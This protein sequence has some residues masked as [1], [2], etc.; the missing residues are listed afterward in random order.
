MTDTPIVESNIIYLPLFREELL[1][2]NLE[3]SDINEKFLKMDWVTDELRHEVHS[4]F[5]E[6]CDIDTLSGCRK[7]DS[8]G[9]KCSMLFPVGRVFACARQLTQVAKI[10]LD[11]WAING[12]SQGRKIVC[13]YH[14]PIKRNKESST[15][16]L[17]IVEESP[18]IQYKCP[19]EIRFAIQKNLKSEKKPASFHHVK[20]TFLCVK[21]TC[22]LDSHFHR[23]ALQRGGRLK[24]DLSG[25]QGL[26]ELLK[27]RPRIAANNLRPLLEKFLPHYKGVSAQFVCNFRNRVM[28]YFARKGLNNELTV[29]EALALT[30]K[31]QSA[32]DEVVDTDDPLI[33]KNINY[34]LRKVMK[35]DSGTWKAIDYLRELKKV[36]RDLNFRVAYDSDGAPEGILWMTKMMRTNVIKYGDII[37]LDMQKR[38]Y[39]R[40]GF[41]FCSPVCK[42]GENNV[43]PAAE[44][45]VIEESDSMYIWIF[46]A[47]QEIEPRWDIRNLRYIF[48]DQG[49]GKK[50]LSQLKIDQSCTLRGDYYHLYTLV[51]PKAFGQNNFMRIKNFLKGMLES[52]TMKEWEGSYGSAR[53]HLLHLPHLAE[54]LDSIHELPSYYAGYFLEQSGGSIGM[55]GS[56]SAEQNHSSVS[57]HLGDGAT[58][59]IVEQI[60][61][62]IKRHQHCVRKSMMENN[63][64]Y[65]KI[66]KYISPF[67]D[68]EGIADI[69]ARKFLSN[70]A[71]QNFWLVSLKSSRRLQFKVNDD[72]F[73]IVWP[74]KIIDS[75]EHNSVSFSND[76]RCPCRRRKVYSI[77]C[78]HEFVTSKTFEEGKFSQR[79]MNAWAFSNTLR[80]LDNNA[81]DDDLIDEEIC[82][83]GVEENVDATLAVHDK[84]ILQPTM[85]EAENEVTYQSLISKCTELV[86]VIQNDK[87]KMEMTYTMIDV[88]IKRLRNGEEVAL[89][90]DDLLP[91]KRN[92]GEVFNMK[93]GHVKPVA[94]ATH[95]KRK[96]SCLEKKKNK[97]GYSASQFSQGDEN[98]DMTLAPPKC[99][100]R[101]C[102]FCR[103]PGHG[104]YRCPRLVC[105]G[106]ILEKGDSTRRQ[107]L[108]QQLV[109]DNYFVFL[110]R[111]IDDNK[112][113]RES[114]PKKGVKAMVL[115]KKYVKSGAVS[116]GA[117]ICIEAT[118]FQEEGQI[119]EDY[120]KVLFNLDV[121]T[122]FIL[123]SSTNLIVSQI[124]LI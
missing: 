54:K 112:I 120:N 110:E 6:K 72:G 99:A 97:G 116:T 47:M 89:T 69:A 95:M 105:F 33:S 13:H 38:Q 103:L 31:S 56:S 46:K 17:R 86:G 11:G 92:D 115:H 50:V 8:F 26:L 22:Q 61:Q 60:D 85:Q 79:W 68:Y 82:A 34:I 15:R 108:V 94:N 24:L 80:Q 27:E 51:W 70:Y 30:S 23:R 63:K 55:N 41:P 88:M 3:I 78:Q 84:N 18:K 87:P 123:R 40:M 35:E 12:V 74:A 32:A 45:I 10:F 65:V 90:L 76:T 109:K 96:R 42:D 5:P 19:F 71:Y 2:S 59:S 102:A 117:S 28:K 98:E 91:T 57:A 93:F 114:L 113:V 21:H 121:I 106:E 58:W 62:L 100:T 43:A 9:K 49:I 119:N 29:E 124:E 77:Q 111:N 73:Y 20:V 118:I 1:N 52:H 53:S 75:T 4:L 64:L 14:E 37:S 39:N 48:A 104:Q 101:A 83:G 7:I 122:S 66:Q 16:G 36:D 44:S 107:L 25:L 81:L 67:L